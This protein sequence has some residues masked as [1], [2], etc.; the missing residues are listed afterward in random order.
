MNIVVTYTASHVNVHF[1]DYYTNSDSVSY[2]QACYPISTIE[3]I[4][5]DNSYIYVKLTNQH[6]WKLGVNQLHDNFVIDL[7]NNDTPTDLDDLF[8]LLCAML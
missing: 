8:N 5:K 4:S 7:V 6:E 3:Q 2:L 1:N